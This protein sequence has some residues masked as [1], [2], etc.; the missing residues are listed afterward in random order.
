MVDLGSWGDSAINAWVNLNPSTPWANKLAERVKGLPFGSY[1]HTTPPRRRALTGPVDPEQA[2]LWQMFQLFSAVGA[3]QHTSDQTACGLLSK[4][5]LDVRMII[6][7]MVLGGMVFHLDAQNP[8]SRILLDIC[9]RPEAINDP[10]HQCHELSIKR[11]ISAPREQYIEATGL[12]PL[13][14]TCRQVYSES[15]ETLYSANTFEFTK[16]SAAFR[17]LKVMIPPQ[18]LHSMRHFRMRMQLPHHPSINTRSRRDWNDLF[19]FFTHE[20][21]GLLSLR[22]AIQMLQPAQAHILETTDVEG[23]EWIRPMV[24]MAI[25]ANR[26]RGC[27][28]EIVTGGVTHDLNA[29]FK[30]AVR[31][32]ATGTP[33]KALDFTCIKVHER[34]R[35]SLGGRG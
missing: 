2:S 34:I 33:D 14:V 25:D 6:Y 31:D 3:E 9:N 16:N 29:I 1:L 13:L 8:R 24:L 5:P 30:G 15:V 17:F 28:V 7:D 12:L 19:Q 22:L 4:L 35:L 27:K 20:M 26:R 32:D 23:A 21:S 11:A 10:N 18:R